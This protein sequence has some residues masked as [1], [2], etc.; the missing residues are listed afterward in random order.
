VQVARWRLLIAARPLTASSRNNLKTPSLDVV[1]FL[2][3]W[4]A[5]GAPARILLAVSGGADSVALLRLAI[6]ARER[7][8]FEI[9]AATVD[10]QLRKEAAAEAQEVAAWCANFNVRHKALSWCGEKPVT[11]IQA[12]ARQARYRLL[13]DVA[14]AEHC[15]A[16]MTGHTE[17]D[18]A[19]TVYMRRNRRS[20]ARGIAGMLRQFDIAAGASEPIP[21]L[22]P[23]LNMRRIILRGALENMQQPFFDD[24]SNGDEKFERVRVR[25]ML[26]SG[27]LETD[28]STLIAAAK[29]SLTEA[30]QI[31]QAEMAHMSKMGVV[32]HFWGGLKLH[33][34]NMV[35]KEGDAN[36]DKTG[37]YARLIHAVGAKDHR[38]S[39][40]DAIAAVHTAMACGRASLGGTLIHRRRNELWILREPAALHGRAGV[41]ALAPVSIDPGANILWDNRFIIQNN[42]SQPGLCAPLNV[43]DF[44]GSFEGPNEGKFGL[45]S[46]SLGSEIPETPMKPIH[47]LFRSLIKERFVGRIIRF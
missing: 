20:G 9:V 7:A 39:Q 22:R 40:P 41:A 4:H 1:E 8:G 15:V 47:C 43:N 32:F 33:A 25:K 46:V 2:D 14:H 42:F 28:H 11:G 29:E 34:P 26:M 19:E 6:M 24:P 44:E 5:N 21:L 12:A 38:P 23:L 18:L 35:P 10:H 3:F 45:P 16:I 31:D 37:L 27:S 17:D 36:T 30:M 13:V